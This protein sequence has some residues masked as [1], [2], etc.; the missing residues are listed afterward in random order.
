[1]EKKK[2]K[3]L[4]CDYCKKVYLAATE[5]YNNAISGKTKTHTCS[6]ECK[7]KMNS[8]RSEEER[9][10]WPKLI[11]DFCEGEFQI[12]PFIL[13]QK[14]ENK[15]FT[16]CSRKCSQK[17]LGKKHQEEAEK[18]HLENWKHVCCE[19]CG[20]D[21]QV[22]KDLEESSKFCSRE[23]KDKYKTK[24]ATIF[25]NCQYCGNEFPVLKGQLT[26][27]KELKYCSEKCRRSA[28]PHKIEMICVICGEKYFVSNNR[29]ETSICCSYECLYKWSSSVY[30]EIP[31]VKQRLREQGTRS[32]QNQKSAY[33]LP[34]LIVFQYLIDNNIDFIPQCVVGDILSVD[35]FLT[36][37]NCCLE[38]YGDYW[39]SNPRKYG[40]DGQKF[41]LNELQKKNKQKDI[42]RHNI[43]TEKYGFLFYSLWEY[44]IKR[45][46]KT[47]MN[48]FF[49]Y[50]DSK[51]RNE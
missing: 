21:F 34:E 32:Q 8:V 47:E 42:R 29:K 6:K 5:T 15:S 35:F 27:W 7:D 44:D 9:K 14:L 13:K 41:P 33:T 20:K 1:M 3:E 40:D 11:C 36:E 43:L 39:H 18:R 4:I 46:L 48:K 50:I 22:S 38:V 26:F 23:C 2:D 30:S 12:S 17:F 28:G 51:I 25:L 24:N 45:D 49:E 37:Y 19:Y 31:E 10:N 16:C